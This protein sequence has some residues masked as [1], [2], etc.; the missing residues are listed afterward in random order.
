M[1]V[2]EDMVEVV[3]GY[4]VLELME[5]YMLALQSQQWN[6]H[7]MDDHN[8]RGRLLCAIHIEDVTTYDLYFGYFQYFAYHY[9]GQI[10]KMYIYTCYILD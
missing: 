8:R 4:V 2:V 5:G 7:I 1:I 10:L 9:F 6:M 3:V